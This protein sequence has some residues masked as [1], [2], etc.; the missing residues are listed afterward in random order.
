MSI[1]APRH[2]Y[3][4]QEYLVLDAGS[5]NRNEYFNGEIFAMAGGTPRHAAL[6]AALSGT[7]YAQLKGKPCRVYSADLRIRVRETGLASYPDVSVVCGLLIEDPEG[8]DTA[9]NPT[10]LVEVLSD[11]TA[12]YDLGE[13]REHYQRIPSLQEYL[14]VSQ[15][16]PRITLWRRAEDTWSQDSYGPG[17]KVLLA[18][19]GCELDLD[20]LYREAVG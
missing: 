19:I 11:S 7:L 5:T 18:S 1:P 3:T 6:T 15:H 12:A 2:H 9:T 10:L 16:E 4:Y 14:V 13:K 17:G 20:D 8:R